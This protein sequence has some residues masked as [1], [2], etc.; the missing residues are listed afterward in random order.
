MTRDPMALPF[1]YA[2]LHITL[3]LFSSVMAMGLGA[4]HTTLTPF[5]LVLE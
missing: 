2:D 3:T 5:P 4:L 1:L